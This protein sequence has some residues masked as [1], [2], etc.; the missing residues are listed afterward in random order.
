MPVEGGTRAG[1]KARRS[2]S[3]APGRHPRRRPSRTSSPVGR[4][5]S[6]EAG[7]GTTPWTWPTVTASCFCANHVRIPVNEM[8]RVDWSRVTRVKI[9]KIEVGHG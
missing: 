4:A 3:G 5:K 9:L 6:K 2:S 1:D 8:D 7:I